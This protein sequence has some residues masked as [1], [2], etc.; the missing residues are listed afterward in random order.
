MLCEASTSPEI[1]WCV[2]RVR[3][4]ANWQH[5]HRRHARSLVLLPWLL[6]LAWLIAPPAAR[7]HSGG[8]YPVLL[9]EHAGPY[10]VSALADPDVG[11]GTFIVQATLIGGDP[12]SADTEVT[13]WVQPEDGHTAEA[14]YRAERQTARDGDQFLAK[15]PFD[16]EG[17]WQV[18][19]VLDGP[20]GYGE[21]SFQVH[22]TPPSRQWISTLLCLLPFIILGV[23]WL[24]DALR[25][26]QR[27]ISDPT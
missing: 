12:V 25:P 1:S 18:R 21:A 16:A 24:V 4:P 27:R 5:P 11:L 10:I 13:V 26:H 20:A 22:V 8:P 7:A 23:L 9:E 2:Y 15:V 19:L 3:L 17:M 14:G 6:L